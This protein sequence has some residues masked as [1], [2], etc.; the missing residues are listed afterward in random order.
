MQYTKTALLIAGL[1]AQQA[2]ATGWTDASAYSCP[3]NTN[4]SC[5]SSQEG[6]YD[7]SG[8]QSGSFNS[9]GTNSFSGFSCSN[10]NSWHKRDL[11]RRG[12]FQSKCITGGLDD[13]P[14]ISCDHGDNMSINQM[15]VSSSQDTDVE[16][17][18]GMPDGSTCKEVHSCSSGGSVFQNTQC[19]G[20]NSVTFKPGS[21]APAGCSIGVHS[22]GFNCGS[23]SSTPPWSTPTPPSSSSATVPAYS[24]STPVTSPVSSSAPS[25]S[26]PASSA[27]PGCYGG[28]CSNSTSVSATT[29]ISSSPSVPAS[30]SPG[31]PG[32]GGSTSTPVSANSVPS[33]PASSVPASSSWGIPGYGGANS[34]TTPVVSAT[35]ASST[36]ATS[37]ASSVPAYSSQGIPGYGGST[38]SEVSA[39]S[40]STPATSALSTSTIYST[41]INTVTSCGPEVTNC[42]AHSTAL[43]TKTIAISTTICPVTA[44]ETGSS[45]SVSAQ[46]Y[47][48]TSPVT[49]STPVSAV[50]SSATSFSATSA[51]PTPNCPGL[52]PRCLNT[53]M[54]MSGCSGN[55]D[56]DCFCKNEQ[57]IKN[58]MGCI[59]A[60]SESDSDTSAAASY[61][62]GLCAAHV[63]NNPA[64]ITACP[65]T[66][67]PTPSSPASVASVSSPSAVTSSP[68]SP[69]T[70]GATCS[71]FVDG[72]PQCGGPTSAATTTAITAATSAT[73]PAV[74]QTTISFSSSIV[75]PATYSTG[76]SAG[77]TVPSSSYTT[78]LVTSVTVPQ[79]QITTNTITSAGSTTTSVGLGAGSPS[80]A[81]ASATGETCTEFVDG[82]PQCGGGAA[83][84]PTATTPAGPVAS[85]PSAAPAAPTAASTFGTSIAT[86]TPTSSPI[87]PATG[88]GAR[89]ES[90]I[91]ALALGAIVAL[92]AL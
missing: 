65:P 33:S 74:P 46:G 58:V 83:P 37:A 72:Q 22:I 91:A 27:T 92:A 30:S 56:S 24:T 19:G 38:S 64:I 61:L 45:T 50:T 75:V 73:A 63:P 2:I 5:S 76:V 79:V 31:I 68:E 34:T 82:Q 55:D 67:T 59:S 20:A 70:T 1:A 53:W 11:S 43:V 3:G 14:S 21:N 13:Q 29:P 28:S 40:V 4:N 6:G 32:Y 69:V 52:L 89:T 78:N 12:A 8:L 57:F 54:Y 10:G 9:Y 51:V 77:F 87:V 25:S 84:A 60:W 23:A 26:V 81:S 62:M 86:A 7:W 71:E 36:P 41:T 66:V 85:A 90:G 18:Y 49:S 15:Q 88:A 44:T 35:T 80:S 48:S 17:H 39:A 16:C 42:P 47:N